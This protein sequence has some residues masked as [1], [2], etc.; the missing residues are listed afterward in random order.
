MAGLVT[1]MVPKEGGNRFSG[2]TYFHYVNASMVG[3]NLTD[4]QRAKNL[5]SGI[6]KLG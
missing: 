1:N 2:S 4:E 5:G 6:R 3:D